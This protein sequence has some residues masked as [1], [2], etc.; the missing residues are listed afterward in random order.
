MP[1]KII[2]LN[3]NKY[4]QI[5]ELNIPKATQKPFELE[6]ISSNIAGFKT[7]IF[8][9]VASWSVVSPAIFQNFSNTCEQLPRS[10][11]IDL[12]SWLEVKTRIFL[13]PHLA[14]FEQNVSRTRKNCYPLMFLS[15]FLDD[16]R[17][18]PALLEAEVK[19]FKPIL[20]RLSENVKPESEK[21]CP[22]QQKNETF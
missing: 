5:S 18:S 19:V 11:T 7:A 17:W 6:Y 14:L 21:N 4:A 3:K 22:S 16:L 20:K 10:A 8:V 1:S 15:L 13:L 12:T 2:K 9:K